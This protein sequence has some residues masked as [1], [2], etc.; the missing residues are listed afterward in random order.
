M[1]YYPPNYYQSKSK[2]PVIYMLHGM[3][4]SPNSW[5]KNGN[6]SKKLDKAIQQKI[7]VPSIVIFPNGDSSWYVDS[8]TD[9]M[10]SAF[11]KDLF[12]HIEKNYNTI[13]SRSARAI[14]GLSMGG[15][16][17]LIF[18]LSKPEYFSTAFLLSPAV[19]KLGKAPPSIL[20]TFMKLKKVTH[21]YGSPISQE[22]WDAYSFHRFLPSYLNQSNLVNFYISTGDLDVITP[23]KDTEDLIILFQSNNI[24]YEYKKVTSRDHS[25]IFWKKAI[26]DIIIYLGK[27]LNNFPEE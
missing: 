10:Y 6:I 7:L 27:H 26:D 5:E 15:H 13:D 16:G 17:A 18:A 4:H 12:P 9:N 21:V 20:H 19:T 23:I 22:K 3:T 1:V 8:P 14:G 25:W 24:N 11:T 2:F